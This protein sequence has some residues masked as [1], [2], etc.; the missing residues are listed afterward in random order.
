MRK[1]LT[2]TGLLALRLL[3][4]GRRKRHGRAHLMPALAA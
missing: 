4:R 2:V 3:K 1:A